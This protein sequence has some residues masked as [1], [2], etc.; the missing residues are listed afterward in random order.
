V[1]LDPIYV[2]FNPSETDL[3]RLGEYRA[4]T[5]PA[6]VTIPDQVWTMDGDVRYENAINFYKNISIIGGFLL[7]YV[8]GGGRYSVDARLGLGDPLLR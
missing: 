4:K 3:N 7:L 2:T 6:E 8:T 1:Q 5:V